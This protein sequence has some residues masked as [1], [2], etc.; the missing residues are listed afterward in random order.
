MNFGALSGRLARDPESR[1][2]G[3]GSSVC[4]FTLAVDKYDASTKT[5][6]ADFIRIVAFGKQGEAIQ[7]YATKGQVLNVRYHLAM[8]KWTDKAGQE[9]NDLSV[10]TDDFEFGAKPAGASAATTPPDPWGEPAPKG[11]ADVDFGF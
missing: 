10:V 3:S 7:A 8:R 1:S 11:G 2:S 5:R 4:T 9:H 6:A